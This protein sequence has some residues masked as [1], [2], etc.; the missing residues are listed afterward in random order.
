MIRILIVIHNL[1]IGG[2][3]KALLN[4][5]QAIQSEYQ[6]DLLVFSVK[7]QLTDH[8]PRGINVLS[9]PRLL[10][11]FGENQKQVLNKSILLA[12]FRLI[13]TAFARLVPP[14][15]VR[16]FILR[17]VPRFGNYDVAISYA[18]NPSGR[19]ISV[20]C[21]D[22]VLSNVVATHKLAFLH[23]DFQRYG[24]D[25][26]RTRKQYAKFDSVIAVS[27]SCREQFL[28]SCKELSDRTFVVSN[29]TNS[30]EIASL[31]EEEPV[32]YDKD[33]TI[34]VSVGRLSPEKGFDRAIDAWSSILKQNDISA[35]WYIV[36]GGDQFQYL[37]A[38]IE[39]NDI[40][41]SVFLA[42]EDANPYR[43][44]R[45]ADCILVPSYQ[46]CAPVVF[47]EAKVLGV[48][49]LTTKT[50]SATELVEDQ[51]GGI[52]CE[53]SEK[54]IRD[55]LKDLLLNP[56]ILHSIREG[57]LIEE[58]YNAQQREQFHSIMKNLSANDSVD[59]G[60]L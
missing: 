30:Y 1:E 42:G 29:F 35:K 16:S 17:F 24:G 60:A 31:S 39:K 18:H 10:S 33:S 38:K 27:K 26:K 45:N 51:L 2:I 47:A 20:G 22:F 12:C 44:M 8:L 58:D 52:V 46:D 3:Q 55:S 25:S 59:A 13:M 15:I 28:R 5:L 48:P 6:I 34:F 19:S 7:G 11:I 36:G 23:M 9:A 50:L 14:S 21:N 41:G 32:S 40:A 43:W 37:K 54:G 56:H 53:N 57:L 4:M 49:V